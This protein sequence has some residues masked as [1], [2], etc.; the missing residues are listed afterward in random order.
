MD[1]TTQ[2]IKRQVVTDL[3]QERIAGCVPMISQ[4]SKWLDRISMK[5]RGYGLMDL[6][7]WLM[8]VSER[9][10]STMYIAR[11]TRLMDKQNMDPS[12]G[13]FHFDCKSG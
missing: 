8:L 5:C 6:S 12:H 13:G 9:C 3:E 1:T 2:S 4:P 11:F 7:I 10:S